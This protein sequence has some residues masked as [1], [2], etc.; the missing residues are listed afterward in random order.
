MLATSYQAVPTGLLINWPWCLMTISKELPTSF[1]VPI[2]WHQPP[3]RSSFNRPLAFQ[4]RSPASCNQQ[5]R[6]KMV[7]TNPG[8]RTP[9]R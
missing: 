7:K 9:P 2:C 1:V 8:T 4:H 5:H 3:G 6:R